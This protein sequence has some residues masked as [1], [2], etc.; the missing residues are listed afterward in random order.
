VVTSFRLPRKEAI[1]MTAAEQRTVLENDRV[2]VRRVRLSGPGPV[3][4]GAR[5]ERLLIYLRPAHVRRTEHGRQEDLHRNA[6]DVVWR[7]ASS[8]EIEHIEGEHDV[9]IVEFKD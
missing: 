6:G 2:V 5:G 8:H 1:T 3:S 7:P 9:L 4:A